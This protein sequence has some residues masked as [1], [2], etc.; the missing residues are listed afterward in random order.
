MKNSS[1]H[2][3][4]SRLLA[5]EDGNVAIAF[6]LAAIPAFVIIGAAL[7]FGRSYDT[8]TRMQNILDAATLAAAAEYQSSKNAAAAE[9]KLQA[10]IDAG[11]SESGM[12][13]AGANGGTGGTNGGTGGTNGGT[14]GSNTVPSGSIGQVTLSNATFNTS[15][16][17]ISPTMQVSVGTTLLGLAGISQITTSVSSSATVG[18]QAAQ[19]VEVSIM[20]DLT[21]SMGSTLSGDTNSKIANLRLAGK[22]MIDILMPE[23]SDAK[24]AV[25]IAPFAD[26]VN[27]GT[28]AAAATG[29]SATGAY[30]N[31]T[32]LASTKNGP[33]SGSYTGYWGTN[34][35]SQP[36]GSQAG[37]TSSGTTYNNAYCAN[38]ESTS[39]V[40]HSGWYYGNWKTGPK[41]TKADEDD[42][43]AV[44]VKRM[45]SSYSGYWRKYWSNYSQSWYYSWDSDED[46]Y[47]IP[48]TTTS[49][50]AGCEQ[51]SQP[52]GQLISCVTER[53]DASHKYDDESPTSG[54]AVGTY[55]ATASGTSN[56]RNYSSDGKCM[57]AGR[58]L[59]KIMP[60]SKD[61]ASRY[62]FFDGLGSSSIGG[63][64]P[65][66]IGTAWTWYMLSPKW[67]TVF[68]SNPAAE[69]GSAR[70]VA[71]LMTDGEY[72]VHYATPTAREQAL[73]I[74]TKMKEAGVEVYTVGFGFGQNTVANATGNS[75]ERAMDLLQQCAS[76][77]QYY[78]F[79]YNGQKLREAFQA[80]GNSI[81]AGSNQ[82]SI[83]TRMTQ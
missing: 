61:R 27:A 58:E 62:S 64:T 6:G 23:N 25:A 8:Q 15:N 44:K 29:L 71:V 39:Y 21:G 12:S 31:R 78:Y 42:V 43:G 18:Q 52:T 80:I 73:A 72:N 38:P 28:Y 50:V 22:D 70:K 13:R 7:D 76:G 68:T 10:F 49:V 30:D 24:A 40:V 46:D 67:K 59:P 36:A 33:F 65:G 17:T 26:Y 3:C 35:A 60:L 55:N 54:G 69:Y 41:G 45:S 75:S 83:P 74:C 20:V 32:N 37:A 11:L 51:T 5:K 79:P 4:L 57:V 1:S 2:Y 66:H 53:T 34:P 63:A 56:K 14:G 48:E 81:V 82:R 16:N 9:A 77:N 47:I 19:S